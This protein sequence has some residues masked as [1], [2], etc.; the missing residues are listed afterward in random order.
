MVTIQNSIWVELLAQLKTIEGLWKTRGPLQ[1]K[2]G[3][4]ADLLM[5]ETVVVGFEWF[6]VQ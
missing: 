2:H 6:I 4:G 1:Q 5:K 3:G